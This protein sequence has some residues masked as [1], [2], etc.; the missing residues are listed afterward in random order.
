MDDGMGVTLMPHRPTRERLALADTWP[1]ELFLSLY[2]LV[3]G[4]GFLNPLTN[5]FA[6]SP[7]A[8]ALIGRLVDE[9]QFGG[10]VTVVG[11][12]A[13]LA[14]IRGSRPVRAVAFGVAG[15]FWV[16]VVAAIGMP[17]NWAAGGLPHFMLAALAN[18]YCWVRLNRRG[19][20]P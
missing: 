2:A 17:T 5:T 4:L 19:A 3:W 12:L 10:L 9:S 18:W 6:A 8:Y 11:T 1:L 16:L 15:L 7:V 14:A 13:L 20:R